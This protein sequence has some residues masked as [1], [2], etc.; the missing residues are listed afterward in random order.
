MI[1]AGVEETEEDNIFARRVVS[2]IH[3]SLLGVMALVRRGT[4][5]YREEGRYQFSGQCLFRS[6][7]VLRS[8][9]VQVTIYLG[10]VID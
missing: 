3:G 8:M 5:T 6:L 10:H 1:S 4:L 2:W 7:S 9:S